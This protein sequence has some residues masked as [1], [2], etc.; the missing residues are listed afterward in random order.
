[1]KLLL[2]SLTPFSSITNGGQYV[3][4]ALLG[5]SENLPFGEDTPP[6]YSNPPF[7]NLMFLTMLIVLLHI[8]EFSPIYL[9]TTHQLL[10]VEILEHWKIWK[11]SSDNYPF[12]N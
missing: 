6:N 7:H 1:M 4:T 9:V 10:K 12:W 11:F 2:T 3:K 5:F 8:R